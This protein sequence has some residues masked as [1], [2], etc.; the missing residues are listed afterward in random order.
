MLILYKLYRRY[1][2]TCYI[3]YVAT[4][5]FSKCYARIT[6]LVPN[7]SIKEIPLY[8]VGQSIEH[9]VYANGALDSDMIYFNFKVKK[10][11]TRVA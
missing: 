7:F 6:L 10:Y 4:D 3:F 1:R 8:R 5:S 11:R 9:C 2:Y